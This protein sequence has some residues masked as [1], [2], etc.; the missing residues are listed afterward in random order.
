MRRNQL[1]DTRRLQNTKEFGLINKPKFLSE[2]A[3]EIAHS[4]AGTPAPEEVPND[5]LSEITNNRTLESHKVSVPELYQSID[6]QYSKF[7]IDDFDFGSV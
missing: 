7:G 1:E 4:P 3:R 5:P 6:I 2:Q